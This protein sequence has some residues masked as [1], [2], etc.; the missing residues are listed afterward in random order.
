MKIIYDTSL[1]PENAKEKGMVFLG[2][3]H[4]DPCQANFKLKSNAYIF[5]QGAVLGKPT[6]HRYSLHGIGTMFGW[7]FPRDRVDKIK[8]PLPKESALSY[9]NAAEKGY[10]WIA[11]VEFRQEESVFDIIDWW[12]DYIDHEGYYVGQS[13]NGDKNFKGVYLKL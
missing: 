4:I 5:E 8:L 11:D 10:K 9:A 2:V 12:F 7:Y 3:I 1:T 13:R 6:E